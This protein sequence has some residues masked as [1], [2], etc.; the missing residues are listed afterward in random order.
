MNGEINFRIAIRVPEIFYVLRNHES[1]E[2]DRFIE[3]AELIKHHQS[4]EKETVSDEVQLG[5]D[6]INN[7]C[8][9]LKSTFTTDTKSISVFKNYIFN[10]ES[11]S[12]ESALLEVKNYLK[13]MRTI[14]KKFSGENLSKIFINHWP[15]KNEDFYFILKCIDLAG[16]RVVRD[17][18]LL[19]YLSDE[20]KIKIFLEKY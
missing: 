2:P 18:S 14:E 7:I 13:E 15:D 8:N 10:L 1:K 11:N 5:R 19:E 12:K 20:E 3:E 17:S 16:I 4:R 6:Q 9:V